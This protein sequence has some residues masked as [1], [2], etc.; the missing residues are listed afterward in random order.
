MTQASTDRDLLERTRLEQTIAAGTAERRNRPRAVILA[1]SALLALAG[2]YALIQAQSL[3][4]AR[5]QVEL[6]R[7]QNRSV[8]ELVSSLR[9]LQAESRDDVHAYD[10]TIGTMLENLGD[11]IGFAAPVKVTQPPGIDAGRRKFMTTVSAEDPGKVVEFLTSAVGGSRIR[12]LELASIR[13]SP[14]QPS[15]R[16]AGGGREPATITGWEAILQFS[17]LERSEV[18]R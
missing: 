6:Q 18:K 13:L 7:A 10:P 9:A 1:A 11:E 14:V 3:A 16:S 2:G 4:A 12:G 15:A 5:Q 17:R 8:T